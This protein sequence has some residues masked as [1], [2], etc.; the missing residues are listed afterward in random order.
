MDFGLYELKYKL[1][2]HL[3][4]LLPFLR[5][6]DPNVVSWS[7]LPLGAITALLYAKA[8]Q[9]PVFYLYG[10]FFI[11]ARLAVGTLDGM[12]AQELGKETHKG[13]IINRLCPELC[14][15]LLLAALA[16]SF[17]EKTSITIPALIIAHATS[18]L[19]LLGLV[20]RKPIQSV[21]PVGQTD[22]I[23]AL[24]AISPVA[25]LYPPALLLFFYWIIIGGTITCAIRLKRILAPL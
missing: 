18:F 16:L 11:L 9:H 4:I 2:E 7:L 19:G 15:L 14:D 10:L 13:A 17:P 1:R 8:P 22:R 25:A 20:G 21:G 23:V 12:L 6:I 24:A 5:N 3:R